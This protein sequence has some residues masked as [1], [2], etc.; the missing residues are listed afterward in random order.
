MK[1]INLVSLSGALLIS[2]CSVSQ[3]EINSANYGSKPINNEEKVIDMIKESLKDPESLRVLSIT[4]PARGFSKYGFGSTEHGWFTTITYNA[5][6]SYGGYVG[7]KSS[8]FVYLNGDYK[9]AVPMS[10]GERVMLD[11]VSFSCKDNCQVK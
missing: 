2:A 10:N 1:I 9:V 3:N 11:K 7:A 5:K 4:N 6:N 8:T